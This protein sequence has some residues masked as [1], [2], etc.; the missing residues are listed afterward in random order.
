[1][2]ERFDHRSIQTEMTSFPVR[3]QTDRDALNQSIYHLIQ[4]AIRY[5]THNSAIV[6]GV[7]QIRD[8]AIIQVRDRGEGI[9][10]SQ[11]DLIFKPFYRID[12]SRTRSTGG[13]G[14]GLTIVKT[15]VERMGGTLLIDSQP[16]IGSTFTLTL[17]ILETCS[18]RANLRF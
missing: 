3:V 16:G 2:T 9:P 8:Q 13:T 4:N 10:L 5:S 15:L 7:D 18:K 17:P 14:L 1:M 12:P 11:Q 6:I